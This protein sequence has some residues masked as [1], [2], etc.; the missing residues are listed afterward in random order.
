MRE[1]KFSMNAL[2]LVVIIFS[3]ITFFVSI[4]LV[5]LADRRAVNEFYPVEGTDVAVR[6]SN[7]YPNG[8]YE[9]DRVNGELKVPGDF[10]HDW[11]AAA[12]GD[13]LYVNEHTRTDMGMIIC[14]V[15]RVDLNTFEKEVLWR[16]TM[17]RGRCASGELV[18]LKGFLM[19]SN[20]PKTNSL[21]RLY[22]ESSEDIRTE[23]EGGVVMFVDGE[24]GEIL[25]SVRD[26]EA[27]TDVFERRYLE[28]TLEEVRG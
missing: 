20:F 28:R 26:D 10:G 19:P 25:Y 4:R 11:G 22:S 24:S 7:L 2:V 16:D 14:Q 3:A 5:D 18:C 17:L 1:T 12:I 8:I 6:Y 23:S 13:Q 15:V 9:G 27:Q 21:C